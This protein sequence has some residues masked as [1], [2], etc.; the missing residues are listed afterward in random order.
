MNE[1]ELVVFANAA[2]EFFA[3]STGVAAE[4]GVAYLK[5]TDERILSEFTG[6]VAFSGEREGGV[7]VTAPA[8]ML[9]ELTTIFT[10]LENPEISHIRDM[11][12]ELANHIAGFATNAFGPNLE[13]SV[14]IVIE[15]APLNIELPVRIPVFVVPIHWHGHRSHIVV[16]IAD[17]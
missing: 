6:V 1:T 14:P 10:G 15:G 3:K 16:G 7:Y 5:K 13:I 12:G 2:R 9:A 4:L 17:K 8:A 11:V